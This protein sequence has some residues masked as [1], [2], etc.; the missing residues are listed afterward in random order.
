M[1]NTLKIKTGPTKRWK[2]ENSLM[3]PP[4]TLVDVLAVLMPVGWKAVSETY[5]RCDRSS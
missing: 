3:T 1:P 2:P 4:L 5:N